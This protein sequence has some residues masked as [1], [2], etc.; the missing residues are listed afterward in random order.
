MPSRPLPWSTAQPV[1]PPAG[2]PETLPW[3]SAIATRRPAGAAPAD[4]FANGYG[5]SRLDRSIT[6]RRM[7][8]RSLRWQNRANGVRADS[9]AT[10]RRP[11]AR[12]FF[13][14][15]A[16]LDSLPPLLATPDLPYAGSRLAQCQPIRLQRGLDLR[17]G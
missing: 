14:R 17:F 2:R 10:S 16:A 12:G 13:P 11:S 5:R 7:P 15:L 3:Q 8:V 9:V 4:P 1:A 6:D